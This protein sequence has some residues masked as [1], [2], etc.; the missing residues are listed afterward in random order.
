MYACRLPVDG[1]TVIL[2]AAEYP[3]IQPQAVNQR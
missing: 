1:I 3:W 2:S